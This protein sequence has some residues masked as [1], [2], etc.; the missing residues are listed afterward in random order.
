MSLTGKPEPKKVPKSEQTHFT[1]TDDGITFDNARFKTATPKAKD[2]SALF[3]RFGLDENE[4]E[5][6]PGSAVRMGSW[7]QSASYKGARDVVQLFSFRAHFRRRAA[8]PITDE[9]VEQRREQLRSFTLP[10][11]PPRSG[12]EEVAAVINL[13]DIQGGKSEGGGVAATGQRL[14]DGLVNVQAWLERCR[15][16]YNITEVV[17]VNNGDPVEGCAGNYDQQMFTVELNLRQQMN[18]ILDAWTTYARELFP[19]FEK[20][21]FISVL[22]NHGELGRH[23]GKKNRTDDADNLGGFLAESL[24]RV[25]DGAGG[26]EHVE[27]TI[28]EDEMNVYATVA[29][30]PM[31]FNHGHKIPGSDASGFEKWLNGQVRGDRDAWEARIWQTA[32]RHHFQALD[33]GSCSVFQSPSLDG[34]S[35]WLRDST[36]KFSNSGIIAYLVG[37]HSKLGWSD[38]AF[39]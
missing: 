24:K 16:H 14:V 25:L 7:D 33:L 21:Q 35:K 4:F 10:P 31:A 12:G 38:L 19:R 3:E 28:P 15:T 37:P 1:E 27:W 23:G 11:R 8:K 18:F 9:E 5:L 32:H 20:A 22:C 30:V 36:G 17:I 29:G 26:F 34:G 13:A 6:E 2:W 39:L